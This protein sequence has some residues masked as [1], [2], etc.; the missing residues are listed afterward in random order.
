MGSN[1]VTTYS[2][3]CDILL[4]STEGFMLR[5]LSSVVEQHFRKVEVPGSNPGGG[6]KRSSG[7]K[8][9]IH[10]VRVLFAVSIVLHLAIWWYRAELISFN[11]LPL[12]FGLGM[13]LLNLGLALFML[14][15]DT[16]VSTILGIASVFIQVCIGILL[17][18]AQGGYR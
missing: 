9:Y 12:L 2:R 1:Q 11:P 16:V 14:R 6:S 10:Y 8:S 7:R 3:T 4:P 17:V 15:R 5:R 18:V 13:L